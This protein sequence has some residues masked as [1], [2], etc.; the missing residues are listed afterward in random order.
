M[1][2]DTTTDNDTITVKVGTKT[3]KLKVTDVTTLTDALLAAR[4]EAYENLRVAREATKA[5]QKTEREA[6]KRVKLEERKAALE[7]KLAELAA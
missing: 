7:A 3:L 2:V 4:K 6:A 5:A 1:T